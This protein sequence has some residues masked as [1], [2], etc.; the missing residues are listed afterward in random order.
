MCVPGL[1]ITGTANVLLLMIGPYSTPSSQMIMPSIV[2]P[3]TEGVELAVTVKPGFTVAAS[4]GELT[5]ITSSEVSLAAR[6]A[7]TL[8]RP[9]APTTVHSR[10]TLTEAVEEG[11]REY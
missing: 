1:V 5:V 11:L 3:D 6:A 2:A 7:G 8:Y 4:A 10:S 9:K